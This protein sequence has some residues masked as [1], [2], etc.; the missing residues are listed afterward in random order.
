MCV[1]VAASKLPGSSRVTSGFITSVRCSGQSVYPSRGT[2]RR[3]FDPWS[4][5][6]WSLCV[7]Y[8]IAL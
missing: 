5:I 2:S 4:C 6:S 1:R 3:A 7:W 8:F